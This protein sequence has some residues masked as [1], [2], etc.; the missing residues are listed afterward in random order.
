MI[1]GRP[2]LDEGIGAGDADFLAKANER[3]DQF[4]R[5]AGILVLATHSAELMYRMCNKA[6]LMEHGKLI[7]A[8]GLDE[9]IATYH[10]RIRRAAAQSTP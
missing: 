3:L 7:H 6:I 8:G 2:L 4:I 1:L 9:V 10:E 5:K